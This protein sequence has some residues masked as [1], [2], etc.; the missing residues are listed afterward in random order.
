MDWTKTTS[1]RNENHLC[2]VNWCA[3]Y[4]RFYGNKRLLLQK[5]CTI[6]VKSLGHHGVLIHWLFNSLFRVTTKKASQLHIA[7]RL[8]GKSTSHW[9][10]PL[11]KS[12]WCRKCF[13]IITSCIPRKPA[14][15]IFSSNTSYNL[16][17]NLCVWKWKWQDD[18]KLLSLLIW[19]S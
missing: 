13:H 14:Q 2:S 12:L 1:R 15:A 11:T 6:T 18:N 8:W 16:Y 17:K 7:G 3:L 9:W 4:Y 5:L 19:P 10:I